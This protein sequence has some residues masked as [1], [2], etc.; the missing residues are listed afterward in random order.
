MSDHA[1][2][3]GPMLASLLSEL[4]L[5][6][7]LL[8]LCLRLI[9]L[10]LLAVD[11]RFD[12]G[13]VGLGNSHLRLGLIDRD[14]VITIVDPCEQI[15]CI[16]VLIVGDGNRDDITAD[17]RRDREAPSGH[18]R[19]VGR[20]KMADVQPVS[21]TTDQCDQEHAYAGDGEHPMLAKT[22]SP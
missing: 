5:R 15:A 16:D 22:V 18:E 3:T 6:L 13:V 12:I 8:H 1:R 10:R 20:F 14:P 21:E 17:S 19:I 7:G 4:Q 2:N 11:L 9:D